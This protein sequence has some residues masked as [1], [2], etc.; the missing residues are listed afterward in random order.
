MRSRIEK[1]PFAEGPLS[2]YN[3]VSILT[4]PVQQQREIEE[5]FFLTGMQEA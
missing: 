3:N 1:A 5:N 4:V 2:L